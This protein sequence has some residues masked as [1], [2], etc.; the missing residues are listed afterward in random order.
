TSDFKTF[1]S[2]PVEGRAGRNKGMASFPRR[3]DGQYMMIGRQD[4]K[5]L[6]SSRSPQSD[7][8]DD[9]GVSSMEP[10]FAWEFIQIGNCGSPVSTK[11]GWLVSTHGVGPMRKYASG[12]VLSDSAD[13]SKVSART[14]EPVLTAENSDRAGYVPNVVYTCGMMPVG[15]HLLIPYGISDSVVGFATS[16]IDD[17][18]ATMA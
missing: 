12:A 8:W 15:D 9:D 5:N 7:Q 2:E 16:A 17:I 3:I 14:P 1:S 6:Y 4:G 10:R 13:P 18:S 11:A